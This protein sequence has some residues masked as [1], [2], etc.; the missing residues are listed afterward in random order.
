MRVAVEQ[1]GYT[2]ETASSGQSALGY[3]L[4]RSKPPSVL[5]L[6]LNMPGLSGWDLLR[7][8]AFHPRLRGLPVVITSGEAQAAQTLEH[9]QVAACL[10]K[11]VMIR[12]LQRLLDELAPLPAELAHAH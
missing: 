10:P 2:A 12:S 1:L 9:G 6:D 4:G 3:L 8:L 5:L 7:M 11:P